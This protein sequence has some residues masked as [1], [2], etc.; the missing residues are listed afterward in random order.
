MASMSNGR[1]NGFLGP[2]ADW[3]DDDSATFE[4]HKHEVAQH[5]IAPLEAR[6]EALKQTSIPLDLLVTELRRQMAEC[7][8]DGNLVLV[9]DLS[10][11]V[12]DLLQNRKGS[13]L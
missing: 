12:W 13:A 4:H 11:A 6:L 5:L 10:E 3:V 2:S 1:P 8:V 7:A 9:G